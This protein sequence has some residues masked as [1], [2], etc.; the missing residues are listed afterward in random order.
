MLGVQVWITAY[1][2]DEPQ[3]GLVACTLIDADGRRWRW[4]EKAAIV[5]A[6]DLHAGSPYPQPGVI[7]CERIWERPDSTDQTD[8]VRVRIDTASPWGV[9]SVEGETQLEV[10]PSQL[11]EW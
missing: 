7:A 1:V 4:I 3:P 6:E 8:G 11:I 10:R 5:S 9:A 2:S